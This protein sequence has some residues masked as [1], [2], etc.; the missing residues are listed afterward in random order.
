MVR[1]EDRE[2][3][4]QP[5]RRGI[6]FLIFG[7]G[8]SQAIQL[9]ASLVLT[10]LYSPA[11]FGQY[12]SLIAIAS[13]LGTVVGFSYAR[14]IPLAASD[15]EA[16]NLAWLSIL[17]SFVVSLVCAL[18]LAAAFGSAIRIFGYRFELTHVVFVPSTAL[19][20]ALWAT[21]QATHSRIGGFGRVASS[22]TV[23]ASAQAAI[24]ILA[25]RIAAGA[26]GLNVGYLGGR[27]LNVALMVRGAKLGRPPRPEVLR[28]VAR[29]WSDM[30]RWL[31]APTVLNL[32][33]IS[34]I[35]PW[36]AHNFGNGTA[37]SFAFALQMVS[38]PGALVG[39]SVAT[40]LFPHLARKD[41]GKGVTSEEI[42]RYAALLISLAI[43][44][45]LPV[46]AL[47]PEIFAVV[48]GSEW[49]SAGRFASIMS[50]WLALSFVSSPLS[51][52]ALVKRKYRT[53]ALVSILETGARYAAITVGGVVG[54]ATVGVVLYS[55]AGAAIS[56]N[57][58]AWT[59]KLAGGNLLGL[60]RANW[61]ALLL[62]VLGVMSLLLAR[63]LF[64]IWVVAVLTAA[65]AVV[66]GLPALRGIRQRDL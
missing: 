25:G 9:A 65:V 40:V 18:G 53:V 32:L 62:S 3:N 17:L 58:V 24:Q 29:K 27:M 37:G 16:R 7:T 21:L 35:T 60:L 26:A 42:E 30:P 15:E 23:G 28:V 49:T 61:R 45:F 12:A 10:R 34:A 44:V 66:L 20:L 22:T 38:V 33:G 59:M 13:V 54:S 52:F 55:A 4:P 57:Y 46:L 5:G 51:S 63:S 14:A 1:A 19:A 48:F 36:V 31:L 11:D 50:P 56:A 43:P 47:G 39:Q 41:R 2:G 6:G 64:P 8:L